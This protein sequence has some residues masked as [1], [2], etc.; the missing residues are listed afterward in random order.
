MKS[1]TRRCSST[2]VGVVYLRP[3]E[4]RVGPLQFVV[5]RKS[6]DAATRAQNGFS[7]QCAMPFC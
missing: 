1:A 4:Q 6:V 7:P 3:D 2:N 5:V